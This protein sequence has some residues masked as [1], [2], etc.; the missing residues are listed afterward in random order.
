[1]KKQRVLFLAV[2]LMGAMSLSSCM[3]K[4]LF[5][6]DADITSASDHASGDQ[7]S[8][9]ALSMADAAAGGNADFRLASSADVMTGCAVVT[10]DTVNRIITIDFG[11]GCTGNWDGRVRK[12][13]IIITH[14]GG[15]YFD[16]LS[17]KTITFQDYYVND[18]HIEGTHIVTNNGRNAAGHYNWTVLAQNMRITAPDG[19]T[20]TFTSTRNREMLSGDQTPLNWRDD[21]YS[22]TVSTDGLNRR[23]INYHAESSEPLHRS[24]SCRWIDSG[25][26]II[27]PDGKPT[28]TVDYGSGTCDDIATVTVRNRTFNITLR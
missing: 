20:H 3:K 12:G 4:D 7:A 10:R 22:I 17:V 15:N 8:S 16:S 25:K 11:T 26:M 5:E 24:M 27:T 14:T 2:L 28:R 18:N 13:K 9:D 19:Q 21:E 23:G 1:M 6:D